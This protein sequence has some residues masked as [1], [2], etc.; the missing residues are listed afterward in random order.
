M[1]KQKSQGKETALAEKDDF[2]TFNI[3]VGVVRARTE[4]RVRFVYYQP[5]EIDLN[6]GRYLYPLAEGNVDDER[7]QFWSVDNAIREN[8]T[9]NLVLKSAFPVKDV[10]LP[11]YQDKAVIE[12][13]DEAGGKPISGRRL[14]GE[15]RKPGSSR[16]FA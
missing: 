13:T 7:I 1:K 4:A 14:P 8:F 3:S 11:D 10:R 15:A 6:V 9:F 2:K 16:S 12:K 5:L